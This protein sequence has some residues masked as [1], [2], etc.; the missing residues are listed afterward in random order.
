MRR[1]GVRGPV[2]GESPRRIRAIWKAYDFPT[3]YAIRVDGSAS[4]SAAEGVDQE[5]RLSRDAAIVNVFTHG[6][7]GAIFARTAL[8]II[9]V[10]S[11][12][13]LHTVADA[14]FLGVFVGPDALGAVTLMFP[15]SMLI[16]ALTSL[17]T[18]G[19]ASLIARQLGGERFD[20]ARAMFAGA[21]GLSLAI[22]GGLILLF[23]AFGRQITLLAAGG[24]ASLAEMGNIFL[25][26]TVLSAP[27]VF[28]LSV[29]LNALRS[30]GRV[31]FMA[32]VSLLA[33]LANIGFNYLLIV[34]IGLGVAGSA[35]GTVLA[36]ALA[37]SVILAFRLRGRT[38]LGLSAVLRYSPMTGWRQI[39]ALGAPQSLNFV[40][41]ALIYDDYI[42][43]LQI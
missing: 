12:H 16:V 2:V 28:L 33:S 10:T 17:V 43:E 18:S 7:L 31:G 38:E 14:V 19:M 34:P 27:L 26:I 20:E 42:E 36:N 13:G 8:P 35:C 25:T 30:E 22:S 32:A 15:I 11:V 21:H 37:F 6:S 5:I 40:G 23:L 9:L 39:L 24:S 3:F 41:I 4:Q 29:H 1:D